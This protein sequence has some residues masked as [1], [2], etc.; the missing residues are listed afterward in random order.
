MRSWM[1]RW[2]ELFKRSMSSLQSPLLLLVRLYWG[3]QFAQTGWGK[4]EHLS[5]VTG[6]FTQLGMPFPHVTAVWVSLLEFGGGILLAIGLVSRPV[7]LLLAVDML[8]AY[9]AADMA[10]FTSFFS[11]PGK[12]YGADPFT[13]LAAS[14][15]VLIFGPGRFAL[16]SLL[17]KRFAGGSTRISAETQKARNQP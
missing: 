10:S 12:F 16:D 9:L 8:V 13:F 3:W 5:R 11:D 1:T 7:A 6:F 17:A 14:L 2:Y 4:L 15:V